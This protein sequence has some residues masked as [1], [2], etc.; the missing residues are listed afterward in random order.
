[1]PLIKVSKA[2]RSRTQLILA[3]SLQDDQGKE[4]LP[5]RELR[6]GLPLGMSSTQLLNEIRASLKAALPEETPDGSILA[7]IDGQPL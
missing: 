1:M 4:L 2:V 5:P 7:A 3:V 6:Y